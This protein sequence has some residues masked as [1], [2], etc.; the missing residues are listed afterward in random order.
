MHESRSLRQNLL[1][2]FGETK[3][4]ESK[5]AESKGKTRKVIIQETIAAKARDGKDQQ[6]PTLKK[7]LAPSDYDDFTGIL[8]PLND[9]VNFK[10]DATMLNFLPSF[11]GRFN[12]EPYIFLREFT[13]FCSSYCF[14]GISQVV[15]LM[16]FPFEMKDK[17]RY[18]FNSTSKT[19]TTWQHVQMSFL[20]KYLCILSFFSAYSS[21]DAIYIKDHEM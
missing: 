6:G 11:H 17:T 16:L 10:I 3:E 13:Q 7:L 20:Q 5:L 9:N 14:P 1:T 15:K 4:E 18:S 8:A 21:F 2:Q 19:F 12:D